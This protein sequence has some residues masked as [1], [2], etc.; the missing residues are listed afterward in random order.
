ME[1]VTIHT[2]GVDAG[3]ECGM[4]GFAYYSSFLGN[5]TAA[6]DRLRHSAAQGET[7]IGGPAGLA[8]QM[9]L[10]DRPAMPGVDHRKVG[11]AANRDC[12]LARINAVEAG[13]R[14]GSQL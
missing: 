6:Y 11:V 10:Q 8:D 2:R 12:A 3:N 14:L 9:L 5:D 7:L 1:P 13:R 4:P